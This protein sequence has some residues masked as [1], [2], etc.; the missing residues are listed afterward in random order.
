MADDGGCVY[1]PEEWIDLSG[2]DLLVFLNEIQDTNF[3]LMLPQDLL[4]KINAYYKND[5]MIFSQC[6]PNVENADEVT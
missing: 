2:Q 5:L 6:A 1:Q 4:E 3:F